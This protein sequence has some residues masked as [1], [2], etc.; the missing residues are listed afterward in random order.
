[1]NESGNTGTE[2]G[3][4]DLEEMRAEL[5]EAVR[6]RTYKYNDVEPFLLASGKTSPYYFDLKQTLLDPY[7]LTLTARC[8][9]QLIETELGERPRAVSGLTMGADPLVY[10]IS[11]LTSGERGSVIYP[12]PV[13]KAVKDHGSKKRIEGLLHRVSKEQK[14]ALIDDVITTGGSTI[15]ALDVLQEQGFQ[16]SHAFCVLDRN[17]GGREALAERGV[18]IASL[19]VKEDF[20]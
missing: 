6:E 12:L 20:K 17:E 10:S 18:K 7:Y 8:L 9:L 14:V 11:L 4:N 19:F 15:Q 13:R 5:S 16:I 1:M 3:T 2:A